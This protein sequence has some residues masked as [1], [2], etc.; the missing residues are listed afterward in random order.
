MD[1]KGSNR[2]L[3][4]NLQYHLHQE[5]ESHNIPYIREVAELYG[6][7]IECFDTAEGQKVKELLLGANIQLEEMILEGLHQRVTELEQKRSLVNPFAEDSWMEDRFLW[8]WLAKE[9]NLAVILIDQSAVEK[10]V[11]IVLN[12]MTLL[13][14]D[15]LGSFAS[16]YM[17][18]IDKYTPGMR[19]MPKRYRGVQS[20]LSKFCNRYIA[21]L[22]SDTLLEKLENGLCDRRTV[23]RGFLSDLLHIALLL[24]EKADAPTNKAIHDHLAVAFLQEHLAVSA[25]RKAGS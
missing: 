2:D 15:I 22:P 14:N 20:A 8:A 18:L 5:I 9:E 16:M 10:M 11:R 6:G 19:I 25:D 23:S 24:G 1:K 4:Q 12:R 17:P 7:N 3:M 21:E 13:I